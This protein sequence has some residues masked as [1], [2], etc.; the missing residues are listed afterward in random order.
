MLIN[1][2]LHESFSRLGFV[3]FHKFNGNP[4]TNSMEMKCRTVF[5]LA[6]Y[7]YLFSIQIILLAYGLKNNI[8]KIDSS[9]YLKSIA[10]LLPT[11]CC[12]LVSQNYYM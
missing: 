4:S 5:Y 7:I 2:E 12:S 6:N 3:S 1:F 10:L 8:Q 11:E 9:P